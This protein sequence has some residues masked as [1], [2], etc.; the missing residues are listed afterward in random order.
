MILVNDLKP[1]S[2]F[3]DNDNLYLTMEINRNKTARGQMNIKVKVKNLRTGNFTELSYT[4]GDK[5]KPIF[6]DK[7]EMVYLYDD[8]EQIVFMDNQSFEQVGIEKSRLEWELKFLVTNQSVTIT[9]FENEVMGID[10]PIKVNLTI[11]ECAPAVKGDTVNKA[12]K[13]AILETGH[14]VK[15]P[16]FIEEGELVVVRTDT[17]QYDSRA[18]GDK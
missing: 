7:R 13:D 1:G 18:K 12:T 4:A 9:Y 14:L 8:G 16:L 3:S 10:L 5:V 11:T 17:G 2:T 6:L 15:V